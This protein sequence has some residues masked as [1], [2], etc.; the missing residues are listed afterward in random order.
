M[1]TAIRIAAMG[2]WLGLITLSDL[3]FAQSQQGPTCYDFRGIPVQYIPNPGINDAAM[4]AHVNG[5]PV[6]YVNPQALPF[7]PQEV[8]MFTWAHECA[9][10]ALGH[11]VRN[12]PFSR[13]QEADCWSITELVK[14]GYLSRDQVPIVQRTLSMSP[15]DA[16]HLP[17]PQRAYNLAA[18]FRSA[19]PDAT[20]SDSDSC[21][22]A[23]DGECDLPPVCAAGTD[24][25]DCGSAVARPESRRPTQMRTNEANSCEYAFDNEC[26]EP[27]FCLRG[28]DTS[29]CRSSRS[30]PPTPRPYVP[31]RIGYYCSTH[32][33]TCPM[34]SPLT[35]GSSCWCPTSYGPVSGQ[36]P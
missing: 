3:A 1:H 21:R 36:V 32:L 25:A 33:G 17:G 34:I 10:H 8:Q 22:H 24:S 14:Q 5:M 6:V 9:H 13:E 18:C 20:D 15:G 2:C 16:T 11:A 19:A 35:S 29:D 7:L 23:Y 26:D 31:P 4:A 12:I 28:T 27:T 30:S